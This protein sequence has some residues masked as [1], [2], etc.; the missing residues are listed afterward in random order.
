MLLVGVPKTKKFIEVI[1]GKTIDGVTFKVEEERGLSVI[2]SFDSDDETAKALIKDLLK[3][4]REFS[5]GFSS[6]KKC[7]A[8]GSI[9]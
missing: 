7:K 6:V 9:Y 4:T 2:L 8:D 5:V 1:D 3:S